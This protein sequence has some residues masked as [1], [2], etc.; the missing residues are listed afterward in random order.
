MATLLLKTKFCIPN[1]RPKLVSRTRL[2][3]RLNASIHCKLTLI[4]APAG[5]GKTTLVIDWLSGLK[6]SSVWLSLD[7]NDNDLARFLS[8][9]I[10]ALQQIDSKLGQIT[11]SILW[12]PQLPD[13]E[14]LITPLINEIAD[15]DTPFVLVL[16]D[17]HVITQSAVQEAVSFLLEHMPPQMHIIIISRT[18]PLLP[19]S[20]LRA[21]RQMIE[22]RGTDLRFTEMETATFLKQTMG[23]SLNI[24]AIKTLEA[25]TEGW[26]AGLQL[27]AL[28]IRNLGDVDKQA[29][30]KALAGS[31]RYILDYL[32]EEVLNQ[33]PQ[34]V[35]DFLLRTSILERLSGVLHNLSKK[36]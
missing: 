7:E 9:F 32:I 11:W 6:E 16:E 20:R 1:V 3:E 30:I 8:Y 29:F 21:S 34:H 18:D 24:D 28:S 35:K 5:F 26:I 12:A 27:A 13:I 19:L 23:M 25:R 4:S 17:Y 15:L 31:D 2:I 14:P 22:I 36:Q 33:Q 10:A